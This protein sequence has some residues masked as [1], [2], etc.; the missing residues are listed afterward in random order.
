MS[1]TTGI[2]SERL[3]PTLTP[4][5][6]ERLATYG[7][8]RT[9]RRGETLMEPGSPHPSCFVVVRGSLDLLR[10]AGD[11]ET[12]VQTV[13]AGQFTGEANLLTG[14][15]AFVRVRATDDGAVIV[16]DRDQV[17]RVL[18]LEN[19]ISQIVMRAFILR[20]A[21]LIARGYGDAVLLGSAHCAG[22]LRLREFLTRNGHPFVYIDLDT[23][24]DVQAMLDSLGITAADIPVVL[25][26]GTIVLRNPTNEEVADSLGFNVAV[27]LEAIR[28]V[29]I[30]G[31]GP[32]GLAAAVYAASEGLDALVIEPASAGGQAVA[33]SRIENYLGFPNGITGL[34]LAARAF[35]QAEKFGA[36]FLIAKHAAKLACERRPY[37]IALD[38][39]RRIAARAVIIASGARYRKPDLPN[40][41]AF[42]GAG[43]YY[44]ATAMEAQ[45]CKG[46]D[47]VIVGG[48]N[49]AGQA[50]VFLAGTSRHV[51]VLVRSDG[52]A[53]S[54][55]RYLVR[56]LESTPTISLRTRTELT[57]LDGDNH[58]EH[59]TWRDAATG[60]VER[61]DIRHVFIMAG[62]LPATEWL[63]DCVVADDAGFLKTGGDLG[64]EDLALRHW[65]LARSPH[66]LET[67]LPGVFAVGDVRSGSMKRVASAVGEGA[68]AVALVHRVLKEQGGGPRQ[69]RSR[70]APATD[71]GGVLPHSVR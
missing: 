22:T 19:E 20:R 1:E 30:V 28:D 21:E 51:H 25:S 71:R 49:S 39:G 23:Q 13:R 10:V 65:P 27:D 55:S 47:V 9:M 62:A 40:L 66:T 56:R 52:L 70:S 29:V 57:A 45:L 37:S 26:G 3:F 38:G 60:A 36:D 16:L 34:E 43:V 44:G 58:V 63:D 59:V 53:D 42:E 4:Q 5:Q 64:A 46:E 50:A 32:A 48:G 67:S 6:V 2:L 12:L 35:A 61:R 7:A 41:T 24:Q 69:N 17:R 54:M 8:R 15:S 31:A 68:A 14:R 11:T 18:Q 33:S